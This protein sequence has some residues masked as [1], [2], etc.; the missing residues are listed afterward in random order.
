VLVRVR[1]RIS[2]MARACVLVRAR[3]H[4]IGED[5]SVCARVGEGEAHAVVRAYRC[6]YYTLYCSLQ[7][8]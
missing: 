4:N 2:V 5:E 6:I 3:A 1:V 7:I 8:E